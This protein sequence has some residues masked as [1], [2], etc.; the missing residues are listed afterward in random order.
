MRRRSHD[1]DGI[2]ATVVYD[3]NGE[4][5]EFSVQRIFFE[6][7]FNVFLFLFCVWREKR[8][9]IPSGF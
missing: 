4:G 7:Q 3:Y 2:G 1:G 9:E 6:G 8:K 5:F